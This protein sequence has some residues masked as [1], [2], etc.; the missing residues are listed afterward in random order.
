MLCRV[1]I[2]QASGRTRVDT[3][4]ISYSICLSFLFFCILV[5]VLKPFNPYRILR[6]PHYR[7]TRQ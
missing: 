4:A 7:T 6:L 5:T 1:K 2:S 3:T